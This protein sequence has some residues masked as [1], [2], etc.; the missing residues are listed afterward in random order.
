MTLFGPEDC[1]HLPIGQV[2]IGDFVSYTLV[3]K[4]GDGRFWVIP[5]VAKGKARYTAWLGT[6]DGGTF[7]G[8]HALR[9]WRLKSRLAK[10]LA[11]V[12]ALDLPRDEVLA[13]CW[14]RHP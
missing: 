3:P 11:A 12:W 8:G 6:A 4:T 9:V 2:N 10:P 7:T 5:V 14:G 1:D 13:C